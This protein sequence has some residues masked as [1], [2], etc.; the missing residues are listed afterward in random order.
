MNLWHDVS[1]GKNAPASIN[2]LVE[3]S[4]GSL[5]KYELD[6]ETG[7]IMLDRVSHTAQTYPFDYAMVPQTLW[8]DGDPLDVMIITTEPIPPGILVEVRPLGVMHMIDD[9][10]GDDKIIAVPVGDK[11]FD[12][13]QDI[14]DVSPH[15]IKTYQHFYENY[16]KLQNKVVE[17]P[18]VEGKAAAEAA[19]VKS[20]EL[21]KEK[22]GA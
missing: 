2:V 8:E 22:F 9:G 14:E 16:K 3:I 12:H 15:L 21:Y 10:E 20:M 4:R 13:M 18:G 17:I 5:N 1:I 7:L 19:I 6:K 11:R